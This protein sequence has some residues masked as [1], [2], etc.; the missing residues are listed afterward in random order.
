MPFVQ[1][2]PYEL[3]SVAEVRENS[4]ARV[5]RTVT[6]ND[7]QS[8]RAK[9]WSLWQSENYSSITCRRI[10]LQQES[11]NQTDARIG[12]QSQNQ[13]SLHG[14]D[15]RYKSQISIAQ[16]GRI[17][18]Y[19]FYSQPAL[20]FRYYL[21]VEAPRLVVSCHRVGCV[22]AQDCLLRIKR[23]VNGNPGRR[24][25][26]PGFAQSNCYDRIGFHSD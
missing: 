22:F 17:K 7:Y 6:E 12:D 19:C 20:V 2:F 14:N 23:T 13:T 8:V 16:F 24:G 10:Y 26:A 25:T 21:S 18:L 3:L 15:T 5:K 1:T 4:A 11:G 9:P